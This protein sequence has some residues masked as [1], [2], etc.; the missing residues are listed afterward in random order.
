MA[1]EGNI[2]ENEARRQV[3]RVEI[4]GRWTAEDMSSSFLAFGELY[5]IRLLLAIEEQ[6]FRETRQILASAGLAPNPRLLLRQWLQ[7]VGVGLRLSLFDKLQRLQAGQ[8]FLSA[9]E[10]LAVDRIQYGSLGFKDL[11]GIGE[12]VGHI[13]DFIL[14]LIELVISSEKRR[15]DH[16]KSRLELAKEFVKIAQ[17]L[18]YTRT[19][20]RLIFGLVMQNQE[21]LIPLIATG[22]IKSARLVATEAPPKN[23]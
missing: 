3:L 5:L 1:S 13:K 6:S 22:K 10:T 14:K 9:D 4:D 2:A 8:L 11:T 18:G 19:E 23:A 15:E 17:E 21:Q 16:K 7:Q 12:I 20:Q